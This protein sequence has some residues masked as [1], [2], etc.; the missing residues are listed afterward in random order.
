MIATFLSLKTF[1]EHILNMKE[2]KVRAG[3]DE[4]SVELADTLHKRARGMSFR[5][6]GKMLFTFQRDTNANID[7]MFLSEPLHLYF[8]NSEKTVVE[9][10]KAEPWGWNPRTWRLYSPDQPYRYL[11]ESFEQ[12]DIVEG[13]TL[14][15]QI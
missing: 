11:L 13:D 4:I 1:Y 10:Q 6:D 15:F 5:G 12:L 14:E 9:V 7:M 2:L 3:D 8:M